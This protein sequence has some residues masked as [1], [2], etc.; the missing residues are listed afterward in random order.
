MGAASSIGAGA[1]WFAMQRP[2]SPAP[3]PLARV[4]SFEP[5]PP[6]EFKARLRLK[7][8]LWLGCRVSGFTES[9]AGY[10]MLRFENFPWVVVLD[11]ATGTMLCHR[12]WG[13]RK[14]WPESILVTDIVAVGDMFNVSITE[15]MHENTCRVRARIII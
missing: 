1:N 3:V 15:R 14:N 8:C 13:E 10:P 12:R 11:R 6:V 2:R 5:A 9:R 7:P 4:P